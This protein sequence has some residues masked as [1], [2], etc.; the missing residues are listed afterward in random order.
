MHA[1]RVDLKQENIATEFLGVY[2]ERYCMAG[3][4]IMTQKGLMKKV[5]ETLGLDVGTENGK[6]TPAKGNP[7]AKHTHGEPASGNFN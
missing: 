2:I 1:K 7:L 6:L 3:F 4:V 5:L